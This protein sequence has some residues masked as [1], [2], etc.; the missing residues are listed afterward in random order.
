MNQRRPAPAVEIVIPVHNEERVLAASVHE[1]HAHMQREYDFPF[2]I[3]IADNASVDSTLQRARGL[4]SELAEVEVL[5]LERKGRGGALRAAW[6][7]S[8]ADV[9]AYMDVD[10]STDLSTLGELLEPLLTLRADVAIGSRLAAG[11]RVTRSRRREL[12]SRAYN[13]LLRVSLDLGIADAQCGFKAIRRE[14]ALP[15]L[16]LIQDDSWFFDTELLYH[17]RRSKLAIREIPVRWVEDADSRVNIL[18]TAREDLAG[19]RRLRAGRV[20]A[21]AAAAR[22]VLTRRAAA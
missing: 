20:P 16:A 11:S 10:L 13:I 1:L 6:S 8:D 9:L 22:P 7:A 5:H 12:I 4:A 14:V 19:I 3:T 17:A 2:R 18:D 15:L 21:R